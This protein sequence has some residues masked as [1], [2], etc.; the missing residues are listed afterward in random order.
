MFGDEVI[1]NV[2]DVIKES[3]EGKGVAGRIGGDE[4]FIVVEGLESNDEI[5]NVLRTIRNN[6]SFMYNNQPDKPHVTCSIGSSTY[7]CDGQTYEELFNIADKM[8]YLAKEKGRDRYIIYLP[9]SDY[10]LPL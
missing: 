6:V 4:M 8:L 1:C 7:P 10:I 3:V 2:A 5:R 9:D